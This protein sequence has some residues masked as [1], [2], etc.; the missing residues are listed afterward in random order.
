MLDDKNPYITEDGRPELKRSVVAFVDILGYQELIREAHCNW[1]S[2]S[3][4]ERLHKS[5]SEASRRLNGLDENGN[6]YLP[7]DMW[8]HKNRYKI[9][10]FTDNIVIG[11]PIHDDA[12]TELDAIFSQ[13]AVFQLVMANHGFFIRGAIAIGDLYIDN[14]TVFGQ[15]LLDAYDGESKHARDPRVVLTKSAADAVMQHVGCYANPSYSTQARDLFKDADGQLFLNYLESILIA[16]DE[17][18][19]FFDILENHKSSVEAKL[20]LYRDQP[21]YWAKYAWSAHY[22]NFFCDQYRYF[23]DEHKIDLSQFQM[24]PTR[25]A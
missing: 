13:L 21:A 4:L 16:E 3:L 10:T 2:Q 23:T 19:P 8:H 6:S 22:H 24:R 14:L 9:R 17:N 7:Q 15:G 18:G 1:T 5:L 20:Q 11:Y 12:E 25:I